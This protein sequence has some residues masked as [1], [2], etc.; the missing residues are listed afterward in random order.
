MTGAATAWQA[1]RELGVTATCVRRWVARG[2]PCLS[3]RRPLLV[4]VDA[5][6][7]WRAGSDPLAVVQRVLLEVYQ[8]E[9]IRGQP[10]HRAIGLDDKRAALLLLAVYERMHRAMT[11]ADPERPWAPEIA[12][13]RRCA[14]GIW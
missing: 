5:L 4:D 8:R 12:Q 11:D 1:A 2:A 6:R 10:A 14:G 3:R 9:A 7:R 13:L